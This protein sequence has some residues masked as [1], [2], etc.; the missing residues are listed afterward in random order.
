MT[1]SDALSDQT[2][3]SLTSTMRLINGNQEPEDL[4][5]LKGAALLY[6]VVVFNT[7]AGPYESVVEFLSSGLAVTDRAAIQK[8]CCSTEDLDG[9]VDA[10]RASKFLDEVLKIP[11]ANAQLIT[12]HFMENVRRLEFPQ[13]DPFS[14]ID[15]LMVLFL[16]RRLKLPYYDIGSRTA[17][18]ENLVRQL[19][20]RVDT[21]QPLEIGVGDL[22]HLP[23]E[24]VLELRRSK[25]IDSFRRFMF[26]RTGDQRILDKEIQ[27]GLWSVV[28]QEKPSPTGSWLK[29]VG[30][31]IP[32]GPIPSPYAVYRE[33]AG[34]LKEWQRYK[35]YGWLFFLQEA[36]EA[37]SKSGDA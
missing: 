10:I 32:T 11:E 29:R 17:V 13:E 20:V 21:E 18:L 6:P 5:L 35:K 15:P 2:L 26:T 34:G 9:H 33:A 25:F 36:R 12:E 14:E 7:A 31:L 22:A 24:A 16:T 19:S 1:T 28:R 27:A 3:F 30:G 37:V 8:M 23:W 4:A